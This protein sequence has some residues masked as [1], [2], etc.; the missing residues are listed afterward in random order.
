MHYTRLKRYGNTE[1]VK[2]KGGSVHTRKYKTIFE[3]FYDSYEPVPESGCWI[4]TKSCDR[5]GYGT[6]HWNKDKL[7]AHRFS[8]EITNGKIEDGM[9]VC[10]KCDT[11]SCIN[12]NHLFLGSAIENFEDMWKKGRQAKGIKSARSKLTAQEVRDIIHLNPKHGDG[13]KLC[14]KFGVHYSTIGRIRRRSSW[15][16]I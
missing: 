15:K 7:S 11:P 8:Y 2:K 12:P 9:F 1:T 16:H 10:H 14:D 3:R 6:I 13:K 5:N 4:W